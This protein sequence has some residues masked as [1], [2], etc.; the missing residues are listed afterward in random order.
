VITIGGY[1]FCAE[2]IFKVDPPNCKTVLVV[3]DDRDIRDVLTDA[4]DAEGYVVVTAADGQEALDWLRSGTG[5]PCIILLDL[6]MPRMDGIQ[7]RTEL[8]N[9]NAFALIPVVVLSADPSAI[10][11]AKSLNF[12]G[13][14]RKPVQL[15]ALLAAVHAHCA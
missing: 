9:D 3:D 11:A 14:L 15:E 10:V 5:R 6:M 7:F 13:S 4:L 8:L 2:V 1:V 12:S